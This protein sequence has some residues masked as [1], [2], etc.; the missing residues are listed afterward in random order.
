[1]KNNL[2][3][4]ETFKVTDLLTQ[5]KK[6]VSDGKIQF[7][8]NNSN[9]EIIVHLDKLNKLFERSENGEELDWNEAHKVGRKLWQILV[10]HA[11]NS[12]DPNSKGNSKLFKYLEDASKFEDLLYGL[13]DY[14]RD[15]TLHSLWVYF[16]G[17]NLLRTDLEHIYEQPNWY[18][19]NDIKRD[20]TK[21]QFKEELV[22]YSSIKK[23][24]LCVEVNSHKDAIWC[25]IALCHDLGYSLA[26]LNN[27]NERVQKVLE[28]FDV[29]D[30]R[31]LGY[32]LNI[33]HQY[34]MSQFL[35]L[36]AMDVRIVPSEDYAYEPLNS[37]KKNLSDDWTEAKKKWAEAKKIKDNANEYKKKLKDF[38]K[39]P[40]SQKLEDKVLIKCYRDDSTY[41]RLSKALEQKEHGIL[42]A[43]L[44]YKILG[45]FAESSMRGPAEEWGL[46]N[47]EAQ[48]NIIRGDILFAIAQ[49]EFD[50][51]HL[52]QLG[53]FADVLIIADEL[54]EFSRLGRQMLTRKYTHTAA[55]TSIRFLNNKKGEKIKH[56]EKI[57]IIMD[58]YCEHE[59]RDDFLKFFV[60]KAERLCSIYSLKPSDEDQ[61]EEEEE[62]ENY[63]IINS[64]KMTVIWEKSKLEPKEYYWFNF[65][66]MDEPKGKL[67]D[68]AHK[69]KGWQKILKKGIHNLKSYDDEL[70]VIVKNEVDDKKEIPLTKWV[71]ELNNLND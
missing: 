2:S 60:R 37:K 53:S 43:Y 26:K 45:I 6:N 57:D 63:C 55:K 20:Q 46:D 31:H 40:S 52:K 18:V 11:L 17:D 15:H 69:Y 12:I 47:N 23:E 10:S 61:E 34:H 35:E 21:Y 49:H 8:E 41:W 54:E 38:L 32:S 14:Y 62:K 1:M 30:F 4:P 19:F 51:A 58:Y 5:Y 7:L 27:L 56:G 67:P 9:K 22:E 70:K 71:G 33:E 48:K 64:I 39:M 68:C 24:M 25:I 36:M 42:S 28:Y 16:L 50:F 65:S 66:R 29:S 3:E 59:D 44:I 13:E